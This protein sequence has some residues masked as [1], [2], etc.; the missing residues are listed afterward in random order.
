MPPIWTRQFGSC[1]GTEDKTLQDRTCT[2]GQLGTGVSMN[3][4][5]SHIESISDLR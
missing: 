4:D 1:I 5:M 3:E 2:L